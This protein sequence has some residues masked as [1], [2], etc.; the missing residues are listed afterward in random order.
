MDFYSIIIAI[1]SKHYL[2]HYADPQ[3]KRTKHLLANIQKAPQKNWGA[4]D[5]KYRLTR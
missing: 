5:F 4:D 2:I 3:S 1:F